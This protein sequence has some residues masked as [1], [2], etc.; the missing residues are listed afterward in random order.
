MKLSDI[1][2]LVQSTIKRAKHFGLEVEVIASAMKAMERDGVK[3]KDAIQ[4]GLDEW[5]IG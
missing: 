5:D 3:I 4:E 2:D 1:M